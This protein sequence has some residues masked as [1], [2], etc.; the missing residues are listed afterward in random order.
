MRE[1]TQI[2]ITYISI[3]AGFLTFWL[4][5]YWGQTLTDSLVRGLIAGGG[6]FV[7]GFVVRLGALVIVLLGQD[8]ADKT[9]DEIEAVEDNRLD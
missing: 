3:G 9:A 5:M 4:S 7:F 2:I 6:F 1:L 8:P